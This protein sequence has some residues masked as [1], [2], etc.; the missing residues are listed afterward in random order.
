MPWIFHYDFIILPWI[1]HCDFHYYA[2][3]ISLQ[4]HNIVVSCLRNIITILSMWFH[5]DALIHATGITRDS[6]K[7]ASWFQKLPVSKGS[8][9]GALTITWY[10][11]D[12]PYLEITRLLMLGDNSDCLNV[13][14]KNQHMWS[15]WRY[16]LGGCTGM[17][18]VL[19][20]YPISSRPAWTTTSRHWLLVK[21]PND[22]IIF[23][24][25]VK[26]VRYLLL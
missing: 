17:Q 25:G 6:D 24:P 4:F 3:A 2:Y 5:Y 21:L 12:K 22:P 11:S 23:T 26:M 1:F 16:K 13:Q 8:L 15:S 14:M 19:N 7:I 18:Q 10:I 20:A 9:A